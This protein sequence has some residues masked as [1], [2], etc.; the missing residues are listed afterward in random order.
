MTE[1]LNI[2]DMLKTRQFIPLE[3]MNALQQTEKLEEK[4]AF[5]LWQKIKTFLRQLFKLNQEN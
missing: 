2:K 5:I 1:P 4:P 3:Q